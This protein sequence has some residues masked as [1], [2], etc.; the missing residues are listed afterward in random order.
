MISNS[1]LEVSKK[2]AEQDRKA[3]DELVRERDI[4]NK[5][6]DHGT[7]DTCDDISHTCTTSHPFPFLSMT[8][9]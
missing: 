7:S 4:L 1:E 3:I 2:Q 6:R 9:Q 5:V 8:V